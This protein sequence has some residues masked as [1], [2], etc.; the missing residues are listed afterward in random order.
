[1]KK[2]CGICSVPKELS[3]FY[4][5]HINCKEC[6]NKFRREK[7]DKSICRYCNIDFRPGIEGRY[8]FC[9]EK[10]RFMDKV[11]ID[12]VNGCWI[13]GGHIQKK[14]GGYGTFQPIGEK[15]GLAHRS[16]YRLFKGLL[17]NNKFVLHSC[18][19]PVCVS[20]DHLRLGTPMDNT[21]DRKNAGRTTNPGKSNKL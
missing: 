4:T 8:K 20:P 21:I 11:K 6:W 12:E 16:S 10:C 1:M 5:R 15:S 3:E 7:N 13:W 14:K 2:V 9:S 19:N 17:D 18:H